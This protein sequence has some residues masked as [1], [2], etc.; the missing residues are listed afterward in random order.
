[1]A[2]FNNLKIF[3][4]ILLGMLLVA[5]VFAVVVAIN[6]R[7]LSNAGTQTQRIVD[8]AHQVEATL[9]AKG[10]VIDLSRAIRTY[11]QTLSDQ[12]ASRAREV[13]SSLKSRL[14][15]LQGAASIATPLETLIRN[16]EAVEKKAQSLYSLKVDKVTPLGIQVR[17]HLSE[18]NKLAKAEGDYRLSSQIGTMQ[19]KLLLARLRM[20][21]YFD[22]SND[23]DLEGAR[24]A[25]GE[26]DELI[27][28][29]K[30]RGTMS[31]AVAVELNA[32]VAMMPAWLESFDAAVVEAKAV[33]EYLDATLHADEQAT[34]TPISALSAASSDTIEQSVTVAKD[35][36]SHAST[37]AVIALLVAVVI[38]VLLA[39]TLGRLISRGVTRMT[40]LTADLAEGE[41]RLTIPYLKNKDEIG[42]MARAMDVLR[43]EVDEAFRLRQMVEMQPSKVMLCDPSDLRV[44]YANQAARDLLDVMLKPIGKSS[45]DA[46]GASVNQFHKN[47]EMVERLLRDPAKLPYKGKF[48]MAGLV[49]ENHVTAIYDRDGE[50]LGPM[51]NWED[52]T[53]YVSL[54]DDFEVTVRAVAAS[55]SEAADALTSAAGEMGNISSDVSERSAGV[56]SAA[57]EMG[58]NVRTVSQSTEQLSAAEAEIARSVNES[59]SGAAEAAEA[60]DDAVKTVEGLER[61]AAEIGEVVQLITDIAE[62]TN[63]LALNA[64]IEAAR[65]GDAGKGFAVVANEVKQLANQTARATEDIRNKVGDIQTATRGAVTSISGVRTTIQSLRE[66]ST[67]VAAA[68][69]EQSASTHEISLNIQQAAAAAEDVTVNI[70]GV[71]DQARMADQRTHDIG[72]AARALSKDAAKLEEEVE[73]FLHAMRNQ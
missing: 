61:A 47:P 3:I 41:T 27:Q 68:V 16:F 33:S 37:S 72:S 34:I 21:R 22:V 12:D 4:K 35:D 6:M 48:S 66:L 10:D 31:A 44:T 8:S 38:A 9:L 43:R 23:K 25:I 53:K 5:A 70:S 49:I 24:K 18:A 46:V 45:A 54:A 32:A 40:A 52:V 30:K 51:L 20:Q 50:Y 14:G 26:L 69:E 7:Y 73:G 15:T 56:A 63:L 58:V 1:M 64:T 11:F 71:A 65:A 13:A 60:V 19:E 67:T 36:I 42:A 29:E 39:L 55:V 17:K 62:Q 59:T 28:Q 57:E 2:L